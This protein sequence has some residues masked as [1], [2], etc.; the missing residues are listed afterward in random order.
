MTWKS[1]SEQVVYCGNGV[2]KRS[3]G[4]ASQMLWPLG[5]S[6]SPASRQRNFHNKPLKY[7]RKIYDH[8]PGEQRGHCI[9]WIPARKLKV[10]KLITQKIKITQKTTS[11]LKNQEKL[12][13][14]GIFFK[15]PLPFNGTLKKKLKSKKFIIILTHT[16]IYGMWIGRLVCLR[17]PIG[18]GFSKV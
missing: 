13:S 2:G 18:G 9:A 12:W 15:F 4:L 16:G 11:I 14:F 7:P 5:K 3:V 6:K 1:W 8:T 10:W 17:R